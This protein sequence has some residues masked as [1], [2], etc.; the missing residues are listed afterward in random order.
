MTAR[1]AIDRPLFTSR[2]PGRIRRWLAIAAGLGLLVWIA[3]MLVGCEVRASFSS[4]PQP[5]ACEEPSSSPVAVAQAKGVCK[6]RDTSYS[7][8]ATTE[9]AP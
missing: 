9:P 1:E 6:P 7:A 4:R 5:V 2:R 8:G 3:W